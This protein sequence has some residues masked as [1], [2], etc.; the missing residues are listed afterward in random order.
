MTVLHGRAAGRVMNTN[1]PSSAPKL[2]PAF[3]FVGGAA[4][5]NAQEC[6]GV[7]FLDTERVAT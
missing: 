6:I 4:H 7:F 1:C 5:F 2:F 3:T